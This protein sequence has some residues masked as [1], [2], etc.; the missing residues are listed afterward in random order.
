MTVVE[1]IVVDI[2]QQLALVA[3]ELLV[4]VRLIER[5]T[6]VK[7]RWVLLITHEQYLAMQVQQTVHH[8][9][10]IAIILM[11]RTV[12]RIEEEGLYLALGIQ[13]LRE[14]IDISI[15]GAEEIVLHILGIITEGITEEIRTDIW[16]GQAIL[17]QL[18]T[19]IP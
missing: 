19:H 16:F 6:W 8:I 13:I 7:H 3:V 14:E 12:L 5:N 2:R 1:I 17:I 4:I 11:S 18:N 15:V 9:L 10:D